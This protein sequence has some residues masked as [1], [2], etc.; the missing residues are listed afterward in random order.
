MSRCEDGRFVNEMTCGEPSPIGIYAVRRI[1]SS[2][3]T[4]GKGLSSHPARGQCSVTALVVRDMFGGDILTT[5]IDGVWHFY[6]C[7]NGRRWDLTI[8]QFDKPIG[9]DDLP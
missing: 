5:D 4:G 6:S 2:I 9:Y 8:S 1:S 7:I 3:A